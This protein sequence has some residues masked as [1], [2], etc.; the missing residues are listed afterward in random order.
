MFTISQ[1]LRDFLREASIQRTRRRQIPKT[2]HSAQSQLSTTQ[3]A[4]DLAVLEANTNLLVAE[5]SQMYQHYIT[6]ITSKQQVAKKG[7][8]VVVMK[9]HIFNSFP[10]F[11]KCYSPCNSNSSLL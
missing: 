11:P 2:Q 3:N 6:H 5:A 7:C 9:K 4:Y 8:Y 10:H 1:I